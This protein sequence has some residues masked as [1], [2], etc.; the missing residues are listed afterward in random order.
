ML[1]TDA[2]ARGDSPARARRGPAARAATVFALVAIADIV[3]S[4]P[5]RRHGAIEAL[6][7]HGF[8]RGCCS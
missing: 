4:P 1:G 6:R 3:T 8:P 7:C 5:P 2:C